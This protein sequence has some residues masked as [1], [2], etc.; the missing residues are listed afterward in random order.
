MSGRPVVVAL[1]LVLVVALAATVGWKLLHPGSDAGSAPATDPAN[2][3]E[4]TTQI[5]LPAPA[6]MPSAAPV[7]A[8]DPS[9]TAEDVT[10]WSKRSKE[11]HPKSIPIDGVVIVTDA[12][13]I[14]HREES[15]TLRLAWFNAPHDDTGEIPLSDIPVGRPTEEL[16][17]TAGRFHVDVPKERRLGVQ[18]LVVGGR[19]AL[20]E[21]EPMFV[22]ARRPVTIRAR[23]IDGIKLHVIDATTK[24]ELD[25]VTVARAGDDVHSISTH[26]GAPAS[27]ETVVDHVASPLVVTPVVEEL[28]V[29]LRA[30]L[31]V[32]AAAHA[33]ARVEFDFAQFTEKTVELDPAATLIVTIEGELPRRAPPPPSLKQ[34]AGRVFGGDSPSASPSGEVGPTLC[35]REPSDDP[36]FDDQVMNALHSFDELKPADF[37][38][39]RKPTLDEYRQMIEAERGTYE[40]SRNLGTLHLSQPAV[41]GE[42]RIESLPPGEFVVSIELGDEAKTLLVADRAPA[43]LAAGETTRVTLL[44]AAVATP[45]PVSLAGTIFIPAGWRANEL[46]LRIR[47]LDLVG[48]TDADERFVAL[49]EMVAL[50]DRPGWFR[51]SAG[52]VLPATWEFD[53]EG[54]SYTHAEK[55]GA[56]GNDH[57]ELKLAEP[58]TLIV[59]VVDAASGQPVELKWLRFIAAFADHWSGPYCTADLHYD[60]AHARYTG[61][62]PV[63]TGNLEPL[64][65]WD[66]TTDETVAPLEIHAGEQ[67]VTFRVHRTCGV[68]VA[69]ACAGA[70]VAWPEDL[71]LEV[72][73]EPVDA[74]GRYLFTDTR[75][76]LPR[77]GVAQAG[78]YKVT[79]PEIPGYAPIAPFEVDVPAGMFVTRTVNLTLR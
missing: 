6:P 33:W 53:V 73:I 23:W 64:G 75:D 14:D 65:E 7:T 40:V 70:K 26:P 66:W 62:V 20:F 58:A 28:V 31:F 16:I 55:I 10:W 60:A 36:T 29:G 2:G 27:I 44:L 15:G 50:P 77:L 51:W 59:H 71:G 38:G 25:D 19:P 13:G 11:P 79:L 72:K 46:V 35:L 69:L 76:G 34:V 41:V 4:T 17:V 48:R 42:T 47:P 49:K 39:G 5:E 12:Q 18:K 8:L 21:G 78:R 57:V 32:R 56:S 74:A 63:G 1:V 3:A 45:A 24:V 52:A 30:T 9:R 54:A 67:A 61:L 37:P 22:V 68:L 43:R